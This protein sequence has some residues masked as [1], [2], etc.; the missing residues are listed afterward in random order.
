MR[1]L[2]I[3]D[4]D[5]IGS[6][7]ESGLREAGYAV[8]RVEDGAV[9]Y[10]RGRGGDYD[11]AVVDVMLPGMDGLTVIERWRDAG[12]AT[13]VLILSARQSVDDRVRGLGAG[14]DDYVTKPFSFSEVL[15]RVQALI[16]RATRAPEPTTLAA[17]DVTI[18]LLAREVRRA[19]KTIDLQPKEYSLLELLLRHPGRVVSRTSILEHVYGY[20]FDPQTNVVDVLVSRLRAKIDRDFDEKSIQTVRGVGY[21]FRA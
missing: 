11:A 7:V 14:G 17:G 19:G 6:F 15:A 2:L 12:V 5:K 8:D 4:D 20:H 1:I 3:E 16:R 21:V 9:G 18:D 10:D 13:P